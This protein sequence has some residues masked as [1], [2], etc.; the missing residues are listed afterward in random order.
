MNKYELSV[1]H[2]SAMVLK[3]EK[4]LVSVCKDVPIQVEKL[5]AHFQKFK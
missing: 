3:G 1:L 5:P 2:L 4:G